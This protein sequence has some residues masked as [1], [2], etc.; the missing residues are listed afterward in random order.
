MFNK[1]YQDELAYLREMGREFAA[2][3]PDGA[4]FVGE[5]SRDPDVERLVEG[6][7]FLTARLRQKLE[8]QL[9][10]FTHALVETFFPH[11][12]R[13][14]PSMTVVQFEAL[15]A[16]AREVRSVPRGTPLE[17][18]PVD[19]T[20]CRFR[21]CYDVPIVPVILEA[22][23]I[24]SDAPPHLKLKFRLP[25]GVTLKKLPFSSLRFYLSG[26]AAVTRAIYVSLCRYLRRITVQATAGVVSGTPRVLDNA[27]VVPLGFAA[28]DALLPYPLGSFP[29]FRLLHEY[30]SFPAK[31]MFVEIQGLESLAALGDATA[32][33]LVFE[34]SRLP[35]PM[36]PVSPANFQMNC[37]P[38]INLFR[39][40]ADPIRVDQTRVEYRLRPSGKDPL[41]YEIYTID[42]VGGLAQGLPK[43]LEYFPLYRFARPTAP[44]TRF[45]TQRVEAALSGDGSE[46]WLGLPLP[47]SLDE[48]S[49]VE[50]LS[51]ELT[52]TNRNLPSKLQPGQLSVPTS[53]TPT[54]VKFR[55]LARPTTTIPAPLGDDLHWRLLSHMS[56]NYRSLVDLDSLRALLRLYHF[57]AEVDRQAEQT[58]R[59][60]LDG[61]LKISAASATRMVDGAPLRGISVELEIDED[62]FGGEGEAYLFGTL[63]NEFFSQYVTLNAFSRLTV[64]AV[65]RGEVY[66]WPARIGQRIIL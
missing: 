49:E 15:A 33:E 40:D 31:F 62:K 1:F 20:P 28:Q 66:A 27:R 9:P 48:V 22:A 23:T 65:K 12:L 21:T 35:D 39:Q 58:L 55:N 32:F 3:N 29:A 16:A 44:D 30:F 14:I 43:P 24:K 13:P 42:K 18:V 60:L 11:Y 10:E 56:L 2:Q 51:I 59:L 53:S 57:G 37:S 25:D 41:H 34:L 50:T 5:A 64:K 17:S 54:F 52:C 38:A 8:D 7:A 47:P 19:G 63:L 26:D 4:H 36:P 46:V 6:F 61:L 45:Y